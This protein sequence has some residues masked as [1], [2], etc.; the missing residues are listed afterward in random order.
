MCLIE[1]TADVHGKLK[2]SLNIGFRLNVSWQN[3]TPERSPLN[4]VV[5]FE[6][7][8]LIRHSLLIK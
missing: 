7:T 5:L 1:M 3:S 6:Y 4:V 2:K 8:N